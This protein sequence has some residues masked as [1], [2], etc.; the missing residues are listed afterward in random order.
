MWSGFYL[1]KLMERSSVGSV[2]VVRVL[3]GENYGKI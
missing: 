3:F 2:N 1:E